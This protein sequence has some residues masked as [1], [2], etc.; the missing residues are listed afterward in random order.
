VK[1]GAAKIALV[2]AA[3]GEYVA[4]RAVERSS[5][6]FPEEAKLPGSNHDLN[7]WDVIEH[8]MYLFI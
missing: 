1:I 7:A 6:N 2:L 4:G 8:A 5:D 3:G